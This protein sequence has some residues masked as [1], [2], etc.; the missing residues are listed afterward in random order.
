MVCLAEALPTELFDPGPGRREDMPD[1][2]F[3]FGRTAS[4]LTEMQGPEYLQR[5]GLGVGIR[6]AFDCL[7]SVECIRVLIWQELDAGL[8]RSL[9]GGKRVHRLW[10]F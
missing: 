10:R 9:G 5:R 6:V 7:F 4:R 1:E 3:S 2:V 8:R